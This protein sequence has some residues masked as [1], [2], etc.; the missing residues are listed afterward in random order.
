MVESCS[1]VVSSIVK[2]SEGEKDRVSEYMQDVCKVSH[3]PANCKLFGDA[4]LGLM[5]DDAAE[6]REGLKVD[7]FCQKFYGTVED[8]AMIKKRE[9]KH[10]SSYCLI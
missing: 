6:N 3:E 10:I 7:Q 2:A 1:T 9:I 8:Q 4:I 5:S